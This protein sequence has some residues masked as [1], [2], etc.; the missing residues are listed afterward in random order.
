[1]KEIVMARIGVQSEELREQSSR[2]AMGSTEVTDILN[3][4]TGEIGALA[5]SWQGAA[6]EAFQS[7]WAEWQAGAQQVQAAMDNMGVF[8]EQAATSYEATEDELRS[9]VGR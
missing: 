9:A 1:M 2:V 5:A 7:R 4:L 6:S 8:L 3:R